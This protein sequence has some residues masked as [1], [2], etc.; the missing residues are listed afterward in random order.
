MKSAESRKETPEDQ[1][2]P[3]RKLAQ[4]IKKDEARMKVLD[5]VEAPGGDLDI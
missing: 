5:E 4:A 3:Y 2:E 1:D